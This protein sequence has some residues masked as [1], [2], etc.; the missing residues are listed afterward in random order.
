[1]RL[2]DKVAIV[3]GSTSGIGKAIATGFA[4]EGATV[5][6]CGRR[7]ELARGIADELAAGGREALAIRLDVTSEDSINGLV[8]QV[9]N[10]FGRIDILVNN[11]GIS[12]IWKRAE[13]TGKEAWDQIMAT[14]LTGTFL[15][16]QAVGRVMIKQ[17]SGRIINMT[18]VGGEVA[19]PKLVAYCA[20][21]AGIVMLTKVLAAEWAQHN[22]LVNGLG[23]SFVET[24]FTAGLR[25]NEAIY[26]DLQ[27]R[28]PLKRF[29]KPE[30]IVGTAVFLASEES[31][32]ITGQTIF[33]DGGWLTM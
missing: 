27:S 29:A 8:E 3:T 11:S 22:I 14:N 30:E 6:I 28:N 32:Y 5:I 9:V 4:D 16:A 19:L 33:I 18:S 31:S 1:V 24:D 21:K 17:K 20:S 26:S 25:A 15:C 12:P 7:E 23:P 2:Q 13:D 10:R